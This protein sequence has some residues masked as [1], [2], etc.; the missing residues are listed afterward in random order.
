MAFQGRK[1]A[2]A[3]GRPGER[4]PSCAYPRGLPGHGKPST[5]FRSAA[6]SPASERPLGPPWERSDARGAWGHVATIGSACHRQRLFQ[7]ARAPPVPGTHRACDRGPPAP[8]SGGPDL[9]AGSYGSTLQSLPRREERP[10]RVRGRPTPTLRGSPGRRGEPPWE[11][12]GAAGG[13][14]QHGR[15][16]GLFP[17]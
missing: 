4:L 11:L 9:D 14:S 2:A 6:H 1:T 12:A 7:H 13:R 15:L 5:V 3:R 17:L 16:A 8:R 10:Q